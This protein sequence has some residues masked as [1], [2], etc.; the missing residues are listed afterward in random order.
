[1]RIILITVSGGFKWG[2]VAEYSKYTIISQY[3]LCTVVA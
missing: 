1:M 3:T 2:C